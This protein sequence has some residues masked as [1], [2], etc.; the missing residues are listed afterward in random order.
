MKHVLIID[1]KLNSRHN[2]YNELMNRIALS[3]RTT[4]KQRQRFSVIGID[5]NGQEAYLTKRGCFPF[6]RNVDKQIIASILKPGEE[7]KLIEIDDKNIKDEKCM[8]DCLYLRKFKI[9]F[10]LNK[11]EIVTQQ[12]AENRTQ[13]RL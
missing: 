10:D 7:I 1:S 4:N 11:A 6:F 2:I 12:L 8:F 3:L 13:L 5:K 9:K